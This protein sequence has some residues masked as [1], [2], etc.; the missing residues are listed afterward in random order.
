MAHNKVRHMI[1]MIIV[2]DDDGEERCMYRRCEMLRYAVQKDAGYNRDRRLCNA[3]ANPLSRSPGYA[4]FSRDPLGDPSQ[5]RWRVR[6]ARLC[7]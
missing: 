1:V 2:Y 3:E 7:T 6:C 5:G 4:D